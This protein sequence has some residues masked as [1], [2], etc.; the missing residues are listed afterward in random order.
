MDP[1]KITDKTSI[2]IGLL[3]SVLGLAYWVGTLAAN[4]ERLSDDVADVKKLQ[5]TQMM[6]MGQDLARVGAKIDLLL[7]LEPRDQQKARTR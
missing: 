2:S 6:T 3:V 4:Q 7:L 5:A 1:S